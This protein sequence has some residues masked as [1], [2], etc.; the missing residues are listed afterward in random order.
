[1]RGRGD[2]PALPSGKGSRPQRFGLP[3]RHRMFTV[4]SRPRRSAGCR[5]FRARSGLGG[6]ERLPGGFTSMTSPISRRGPLRQRSRRPRHRHRRQPRGHRRPRRRQAAA[7]HEPATARSCR[8]RPAL[9]ALPEGFSYTDRRR[10]GQDAR[11]SPAS[12]PRA[13]PTAPRCFRGRHGWRPGQQPRDRR[14]RA[15]RRAARCPG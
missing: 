1:M 12:P 4:G 6:S 9:L 10:G 14:R 13:T 3:C 8:T 15:L 11:S 7:A 5:R 2:T